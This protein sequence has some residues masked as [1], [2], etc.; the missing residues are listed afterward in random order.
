M[1]H[2]HRV[3][4]AILDPIIN[5]Y[6]TISLIKKKQTRIK[7]SFLIHEHIFFG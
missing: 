5:N 7:Y 1:R 2:H 3:G 6:I 4:N